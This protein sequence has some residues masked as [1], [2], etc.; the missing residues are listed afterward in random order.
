MLQIDG[1]RLGKE[2]VVP[3]DQFDFD[4]DDADL[5]EEV[6]L[7]SDLMVAATEVDRPMTSEQIDKVLGIVP[8]PRAGD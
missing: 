3:D 5:L 8:E 2:L 4:L 1:G 6:E 7:V